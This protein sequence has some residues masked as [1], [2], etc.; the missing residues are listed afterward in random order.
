MRYRAS[1]HVGPLGKDAADSVL[2]RVRAYRGSIPAGNFMVGT[3]TLYFDVTAAETDDLGAKIL[4]QELVMAVF[5]AGTGL[6]RGIK[7]RELG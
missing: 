4:A 5:G 2:E 6:T 7:I 1:V 3:E